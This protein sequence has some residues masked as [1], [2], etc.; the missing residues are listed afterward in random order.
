MSLI[1]GFGRTP[2]GPDRREVGLVV[3]GGVRHGRR[4]RRTTEECAWSGRRRNLGVRRGG[5]IRSRRT[6]PGDELT[7]YPFRQGSTKRFRHSEGHEGG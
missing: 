5:S 7:V 1:W 6:R 3:M 2:G 4:A